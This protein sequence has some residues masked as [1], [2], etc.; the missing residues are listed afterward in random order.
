MKADSRLYSDDNC[1]VSGCSQAALWGK[2]YLKTVRRAQFTYRTYLQ[3]YL[4]VHNSIVQ[5]DNIRKGTRAFRVLI[6][7]RFFSIAKSKIP[8]GFLGSFIYLVYL[9][10]QI[11]K[12][13]LKLL[14]W[15][16]RHFDCTLEIE[17]M[18]A[19]NRHSNLPKHRLISQI[20]I[21]ILF[22]K[23]RKR[24]RFFIW[25]VSNQEFK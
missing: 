10:V 18:N 9:F 15:C 2:Q 24:Y 17:H 19:A 21:T 22:P 7:S 4:Q 1:M 6:I 25:P 8:S 11:C 5:Y 3:D 12:Q 16:S 13:T 14:C 23:A 20:L